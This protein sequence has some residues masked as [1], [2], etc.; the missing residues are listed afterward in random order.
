MPNDNEGE[1]TIQKEFSLAKEETVKNQ[2]TAAQPVKM[3]FLNF[4][5]GSIG[6]A[7]VRPATSRR[8][9]SG[10]GHC[11]RPARWLDSAV[12]PLNIAWGH[13][14]GDGLP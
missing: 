8:K 6:R 7:Q 5:S 9:K 14:L 4:L 3:T 11:G 10:I 2:L 13:R 1:L 12:W